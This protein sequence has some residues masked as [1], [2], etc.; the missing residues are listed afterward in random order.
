VTAGLYLGWHAPRLTSPNTRLRAFSVWEVLTFLLNSL[1]LILVGLQLPSIL[2]GISEDS[3]A[4]L[5]WYAALVCLAVIVPRFAWVFPATYIP[6][7]VSRSL[8]E[9]DPS[10]PGRVLR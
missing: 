4:T 10:P 9:R 7:K 1:L 2:E 8:R 3:M 5:A 6:R